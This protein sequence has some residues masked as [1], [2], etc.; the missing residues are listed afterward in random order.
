[1]WDMWL[2]KQTFGS[3]SHAGTAEI[4]CTQQHC[5][6]NS[7]LNG[8]LKWQWKMRATDE[9]KWNV[10][11]KH[12]HITEKQFNTSQDQQSKNMV[13][14]K[15]F[16]MPV[17]LRACICVCARDVVA[18]YFRHHPLHINQPFSLSNLWKKTYPPSPP[19]PDFFSHVWEPAWLMER[20]Y[21][22]CIMH[23]DITH[24]WALHYQNVLP[25][26]W[27]FPHAFQ[28]GWRKCD[29]EEDSHPTPCMVTSQHKST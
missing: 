15:M 27:A 11:N 6:D 2:R 8:R 16:C 28:R 24:A 26:E 20:G 21:Y 23:R 22:T 13:R 17:C 3:V 29:V 25:C 7:K 19:S 9:F 12:Q 14:C 5:Q 4:G 10:K 18:L 1:M